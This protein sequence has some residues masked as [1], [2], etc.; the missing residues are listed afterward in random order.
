[1]TQFP[2]GDGRRYNSYSR[3]CKEHYGG[4]V[5]RLPVDAGFLCPNRTNRATGGCTFCSNEAFTPKYLSD[6]QIDFQEQIIEGKIFFAKRYRNS[7]GYFAY[8]QSFT[9]TYVP[10]S[11]LRNYCQSVL[12]IPDIKGIIISTRPDCLPN[13]T[14]QFLSELSQ[15]TDLCVEIGVESFSNDTLSHVNRGH[16]VE[17]TFEAFEKLHDHGIRT[18]AH[19]IFGLP[20]ETPDQWIKEVKCT[21]ILKPDFLKFHQLQ[22]FKGTP[23]ESEYSNNPERFWTFTADGYVSFICDYL[24]RLSPDIVIERICAEVPP[25]FLSVSNWKLLRHD[26]LVKKVE[27]ELTQRD[28]Y[29]GVFAKG[30]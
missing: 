10:V 7:L 1:M 3:Y 12:E 15:K 17:C 27:A 23:I 14:L 9:N 16:S 11:I 21:N 18:C 8:F 19:L 2:W 29:Q 28:T 25:R 13:A 5:Q 4:R 20:G 22:I 6:K 30:T 26:T 24:E